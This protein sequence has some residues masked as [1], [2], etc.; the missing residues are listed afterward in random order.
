MSF[1]PEQ[2]ACIA[3]DYYRD[4]CAVIPGVLTA[5][6]VAALIATS[7][8]LIDDPAIA[9]SGNLESVYG[10]SVLRYAYELAPIFREMAVNEKILSLMEAILGPDCRFN[11]I[12][13][14]RSQ[15]GEAISVWHV[16]DMVEF[17]LPEEVARFDP[18][19]RM[20][21][22]WMTVQVAL[23]DID[24]LEHGP[25]QYVPG[26]HYSGRRPNS[27]ENPEFEGRGPEAVLCKAGD[28]YLQN[29]Q[30]WHRGAPNTSD[31]VRYIMQLQYSQRWVV[32][33]FN[34]LLNRPLPPPFL[35]ETDTRFLKL[36]G[37]SPTTS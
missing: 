27:Q 31:R 10:V 3:A 22:F 37:K 29:H 32:P 34:Y 15:E 1:A 33:R 35:E 28:V 5:D 9:T 18:R 12:N 20:P 19:I 11:A 4:G 2:I 17:P 25:T 14:L 8:A 24:S 36:M 6:E 26:S 13:V 7:D 16:D 21:T 23:S 30:C